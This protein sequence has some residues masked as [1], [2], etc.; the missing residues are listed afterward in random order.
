[1]SRCPR[2]NRFQAHEETEVMK[3]EQGYEI[4][5]EHPVFHV[6]EA[7]GTLQ[8]PHMRHKRDR[9]VCDRGSSGGSGLKFRQL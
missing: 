3:I 2:V 1:M 4:A 5:E 8:K 9:F 6:Q 7:V